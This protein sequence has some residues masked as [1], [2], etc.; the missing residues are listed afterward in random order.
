MKLL[1]LIITILFVLS[2][3]YLFMFSL[4]QLHLTYLYLKRVKDKKT[5]PPP[6]T[7]EPLVT[8]QLPVY[9]E[10]YVVERLIDALTRIDYHR[11]KLEIQF[12]DHS[13]DETSGII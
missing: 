5:P 13:T 10:K 6:L 8:I 12:L 3:F 1:E 11:Q 2:L 7:G 9:N 4:G